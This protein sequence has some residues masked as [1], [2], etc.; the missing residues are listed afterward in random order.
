MNE[1]L[2]QLSDPNEGKTRIQTPHGWGWTSD[3]VEVTLDNGN[4]V[5]LI[6]VE[7]TPIVIMKPLEVLS[8][9]TPA[10][11][12]ALTMSTDLSVSI[13]RQRLIA[14]SE[15]RSDDPRTAEGA[16]VLVKK[17]ILTAERVKVIFPLET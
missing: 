14:A 17:G 1:E 8:R 15:V 16:A 6:E 13:V 12:A 4:V 10:E 11:E 7:N 5:S 9:M 3:G 2:E